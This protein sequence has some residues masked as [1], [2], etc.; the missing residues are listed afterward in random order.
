M[1]PVAIQNPFE[2]AQVASS[3]LKT[4]KA[5]AGPLKKALP[6]H[7]DA[8]PHDYM[9][10]FKYNH[11]LPLH[12]KE[13]IE[14]PQDVN[15]K[16]VADEIA[17]LI[18][19]ATSKGDPKAFSELFLEHGVWR[20][21][22]A[23]T[24]DYRTFNWRPAILKAAT[25]LLPEN[26]ISKV[27]VIDPPP[28]VERP[29]EDLS[30]VQA[31]IGFQTNK[32]GATALCNIV[33]TKDGYKIWTFNSAIE[34]LHGFPE[35]PERD[36]HMT[37]PH[38][39]NQQRDIDTKLEG[40]EPEVLIVGGGQNGLM[41]GA[42]L[43]ALGVNALIVERN[44]RIGDNWRGR[45]EALSLHLPHWADHFAYM[46]YPEQHW[47]TYCPAEKLGDWFEW[48]AS[49]MEL[50]IWTGSSVTGAQQDASGNW[51]VEVNRGGQGKRVFHPKQL[52]MATSLIGIPHVPKI[53]G[54]DIF[55]GTIRH[56]SQHDSSRE[57]VG[58]KVL[59]VG[60]SSSGFDTSYDFARRGIDV[61][62]LQRSPTYIM[63]LTHSVPRL[64]AVYKPDENGKR[65]DI[66]VAD[67]IAHGMPVGP[68][69]ELGRRLGQELTELDHDLLQALEDKGFKTW[70]GQRGTST[71]TLGYTKAGG[72]YFD[73][74]ACKQIIEGKIKVEQGYID[75]FTKDKVVL[76]G[77]RE[78]TYDLVVLATG[79]SNT[80][81][82]IRRTLGDDVA[83]RC[84]PVWG[85]DEEGELN[86]AW[87]DTGVP[88]LWV[89]VGTLQAARYHSKK[90]ALNIKARLEGICKEPYLE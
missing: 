52:V 34:S 75:H 66:E 81:D 74:G 77:D 88:N 64:L 61:T 8:V 2:D 10:R 27:T 23:L 21:R 26:P 17:S 57:W 11:E 62:V 72:F 12:G 19:Q 3:P 15:P 83:D 58:K 38:S 41:L 4:G 59:V 84:K 69:E 47:P 5:S 51:T 76:N 20:D 50:N 90:V 7:P 79:F 80:I 45:Y 86:S 60:T 16:D 56:S 71:Q 85:M 18:S 46:P 28:T 87:R 14:I 33:L 35:L 24:W 49:A 55:K 22:V 43:K 29:Y 48:Y 67:R 68:G 65:P 70:R 36:G 44:K 32:V 54:N 73:A 30:F 39:W 53:P 37:G 6:K 78:R 25:D 9:Y 1:A 31:H 40:T 63:S 42:R 13:G 89:M 82:S